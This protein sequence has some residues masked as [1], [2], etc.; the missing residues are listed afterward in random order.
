MD[1][2]E[3]A[4]VSLITNPYHLP[5]FPLGKNEPPPKRTTSLEPLSQSSVEWGNRAVG[6]RGTGTPQNFPDTIK[7][8]VNRKAQTLIFTH[9]AGVA[10]EPNTLI[11]AYEVEYADGR[12]VE[13]PLRYGREIRA[14]D[15]VAPSAS[16]SVSATTVP[17]L[18]EFSLKV[19]HLLW[20]NPHPK[21]SIVSITLRSQSPLA[22]TLLFGISG[23]GK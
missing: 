1:F 14:L 17:Y 19:R 18:E 13:I 12:K 23:Y 5:F 3:S 8:A 20:T 10:L 4:N 9:A 21:T 15:D 22:G 11:A 6:L 2:G 7:M 16:M